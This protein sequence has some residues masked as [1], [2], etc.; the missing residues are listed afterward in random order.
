MVN[1]TVILPIKFLFSCYKQLDYLE[2]P[3]SES[4]AVQNFLKED[5]FQERKIERAS[6]R[7]FFKNKRLKI[8]RGEKI[9]IFFDETTA[10]LDW[11]AAVAATIVFVIFT[12]KNLVFFFFFT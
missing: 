1:Y 2:A 6:K 12:E 9:G 4:R 8:D 11:I 5:I 10:D 3:I 7:L